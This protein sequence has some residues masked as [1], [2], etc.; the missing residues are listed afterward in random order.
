MASESGDVPDRCTTLAGPSSFPTTRWTLVLA[1]GDPNSSGRRADSR[2]TNGGHS[3]WDIERIWHTI[4]RG[5]NAMHGSAVQSAIFYIDIALWDIVGQKWNVPVYKLLGGKI[6]DKIKIY[7]SYRWG[8]IPRTAD[9]Y[10]R[11]TKELVAEG[12]IA[13][14]W[15]P[16]FDEPYTPGV[17][18]EERL[19][20]SRQATL[21]TSTK[22]P[23]WFV[24][25]ERE[26]PSLRFVWR[27]T[28][29]SMWLPRCASQR[30][31]SPTTQCSTKNPC[32]RKM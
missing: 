9:A 18:P 13:G 19:D 7:T 11:R 2:A 6:N 30:P 1:A 20:F 15:D 29:N 28:P 16:F 31:S 26:V 12:A 23:K 27:P 17:R 25:C 22:L 8:N 24:E 4:Y 14:K 21:K 10:R 32:H 5:R 3:A